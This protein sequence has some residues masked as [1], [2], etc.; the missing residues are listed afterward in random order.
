MMMMLLLLLLLLLV[1]MS[2][3][4]DRR[5]KPCSFS[6][7]AV[8][9]AAQTIPRPQQLPRQHGHGGGGGG[10]DNGGN[11]GDGG[12]GGV[13]GGLMIMI[14]KTILIAMT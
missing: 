1:M 12:G 5:H 4:G 6:L 8:L 9:Q 11:G 3:V 13:G 2:G 7:P 14:I 10:G